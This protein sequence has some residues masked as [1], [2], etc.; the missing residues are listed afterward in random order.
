M[1]SSRLSVDSTS[2]VVSMNSMQSVATDYS[3]QASLYKAQSVSAIQKSRKYFDK[4]D[5][6]QFFRPFF[7]SW[8]NSFV[9]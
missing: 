9:T 6:K 7:Y 8:L 2:S 5:S 4:P 1:L 3:P